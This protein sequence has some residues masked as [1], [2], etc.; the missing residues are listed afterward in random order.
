MMP[1]LTLLR[2]SSILQL[3]FI[4]FSFLWVFPEFN[5]IFYQLFEL[6]QHRQERQEL[7]RFRDILEEQ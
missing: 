2:G 1:F 5:E 6:P 3:I 4:F 7:A